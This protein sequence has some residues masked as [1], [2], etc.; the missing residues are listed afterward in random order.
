MTGTNINSSV[1]ILV[2]DDEPAL[3]KMVTAYLKRLG[4]DVTA[5]SS[6]ENGWTTLAAAPDQF[7][8][9]VLDATMS[10]VGVEDL[11]TQMM[12]ASPR[13]CVIVASGYPVDMSVLEESAPGRVMFLHKPF[14][15]EMLAGAVRRM[16]GTQEESV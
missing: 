1:R 13:L 6:S 3:L 5:A 12:T 7:A 8:V 4:F 10:G 14:A 15:P 16:I 11:A 2:V 9:A